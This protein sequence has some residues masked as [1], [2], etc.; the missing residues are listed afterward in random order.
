MTLA[1][2]R[3]LARVQLDFVGLG[4]NV[5]QR[6]DQLGGP[7]RKRLELAKALATQPKVLLCDEVMA[8]LNLVEIE[9]V[10]EVI[11]KVRMRESVFSSSST[12]SRR[13]GV[14][15]IGRQKVGEWPGQESSVP[16]IAVS[17]SSF[18]LRASKALT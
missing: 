10:I 2:A 4:K 14:C 9:E 15:R 11:R 12:S 3:E 16:R 18:R 13:S 6:A 17:S 1:K 5:D 8:G 7:G